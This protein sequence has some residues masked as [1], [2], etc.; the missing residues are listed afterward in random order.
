MQLVDHFLVDDVT[1]LN[2]DPI[3][4]RQAVDYRVAGAGC[5]EKTCNYAN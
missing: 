4:K 3:D 5:K 2:I 1:L